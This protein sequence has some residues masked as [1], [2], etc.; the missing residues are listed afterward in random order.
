M[1]VFSE[2]AAEADMGYPAPSMWNYSTNQTERQDKKPPMPRTLRDAALWY[3]DMGFP[4][5]PLQGKVPCA[6]S[7]GFYAATTDKETIMKMWEKNPYQCHLV[8]V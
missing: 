6:G 5:F 1:G 4:V 2:L 8:K 7:P 3:A